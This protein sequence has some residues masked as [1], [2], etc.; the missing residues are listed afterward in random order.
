MNKHNDQQ[1]KEND[2][3]PENDQAKISS[4]QDSYNDKK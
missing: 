4:Q 3:H 2:D 1:K